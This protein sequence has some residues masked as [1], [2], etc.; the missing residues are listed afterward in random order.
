MVSTF[1]E[2]IEDQLGVTAGTIAMSEL[3]LLAALVILCL[4]TFLIKHS[5]MK[6]KERV[7]APKA[8]PARKQK[9]SAVPGRHAA[10]EAPAFHDVRPAAPVTPVT[11]VAHDSRPAASGIICP[12]CG[13]TNATGAKFCKFCGSALKSEGRVCPICG[14][15]AAPGMKFCSGCGA[16]LEAK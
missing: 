2:Q 14:K 9:A 10:P 15:T 4:I 13:K 16:K 11:P 12:S 5:S 7:V 3:F 8:G 6:A 1:L